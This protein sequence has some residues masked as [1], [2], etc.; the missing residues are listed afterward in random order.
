MINNIRPLV[1]YLFRAAFFLKFIEYLLKQK[2]ISEIYDSM[3][4]SHSLSQKP[5]APANK[6]LCILALN[7]KKL[8]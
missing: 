5:K 1:G 3:N 6:L 8:S 7:L 4:D 2:N